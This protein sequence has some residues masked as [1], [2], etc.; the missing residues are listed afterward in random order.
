MQRRHVRYVYGLIGCIVLTALMAMMSV[1]VHAQSQTPVAHKGELVAP[2]WSFFDN[3][4][5]EINGEWEVVWGQLVAPEDFSKLYKGEYFT[6]PSRW[7]NIRKP[8]L[9]GSMGVA[10]FRARLKL[11]SY[12]RGVA[13]HLI[14]PHAAYRIYIDGVLIVSNGTVSEMPDAFEPSYVSRTF[15]GVSGNSEVVLQVANFSHAYGGPGHALTLW[16]AQN[17][18]RFLDTLSVTV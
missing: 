14:A 6:L 17:L 5:L 8:G 16:D 9:K 10:T 4:P 7:N 12:N 15:Q 13:Y 3:P 18:R 2:D 1:P 11:P